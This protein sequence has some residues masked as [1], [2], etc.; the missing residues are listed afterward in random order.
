MKVEVITNSSASIIVNK[1]TLKNTN[2]RTLVEVR[3]Q[4]SPL[5]IVA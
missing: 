3:R 5:S 4:S 1:D 2:N